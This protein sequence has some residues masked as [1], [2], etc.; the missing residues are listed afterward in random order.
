ME[1][2]RSAVATEEPMNRRY[3]VSL[4]ILDLVFIVVL[5]VTRVDQFTE[6]VYSLKLVGGCYVDYSEAQITASR[7]TLH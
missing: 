2:A 1:S 7:D 5:L 6:G 3:L 4:V